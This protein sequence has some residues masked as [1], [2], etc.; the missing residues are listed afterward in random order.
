MAEVNQ[1]RVG[2][3]GAVL[4]GNSPGSSSW[5]AP[6]HVG[7]MGSCV[8]LYDHVAA[9]LTGPACETTPVINPLGRHLEIVPAAAG[10]RLQ[11]THS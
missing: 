1:L 2:I 10:L 7:M 4:S 11:T 3:G 8:H 5:I 6:T 9:R